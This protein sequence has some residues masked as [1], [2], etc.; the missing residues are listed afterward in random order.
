[1]TPGGVNAQTGRFIYSKTDLEI[2]P[3]KFVRNWGSM[4]NPKWDPNGTR[5]MGLSREYSGSSVGWNH[6]LN[7]GVRPDSSSGVNRVHVYAGGRTYTFLIGNDGSLMPMN[8]ESQGTSLSW[9]SPYWF[10]INHEGDVYRFDAIPQGSAASVFDDAQ[11]GLA[12]V[13]YANGARTD[14]KY[15]SSGNPKFVYSNRGYAII[16]DYDANQNVSAVCGVNLATAY[17]DENS[18]CAASTFKVQYG[19]DSTGK[20]LTQVTDLRGHVVQISY[21]ATPIS[22]DIVL[23]VCISLPNSATCAIHNSYAPAPGDT[24][25]RILPD[26]VGVQTMA[27]GKVWKFLYGPEESLSDMPFVS[28]KPRHSYVW[29]TDPENKLTGLTFDRGHLIEHRG[30][31]K[32]LNY[33]YA[34]RSMAVSPYPGALP[35]EYS[36]FD[37]VPALV[38]EVEGNREY[39]EHDGRRNITVR[40]SWPK[41]A[42]MPPPPEPDLSRCCVS[43][44]P[45][46]I[47]AGAATTT[48][49]YLGD[50]GGITVG[51]FRVIM[52][53]G[54]GPVDEKLC[55]KPLSRTDPRG[56]VTNYTYSQAHGGLLTETGPPDAN[57]VRPQT[58]YSYVER[59]AWVAAPGGGYAQVG[60]PVWLLESKSLC[61]T[62]TATGNPAAPCAAGAADEVRT[63]YDYGPNAGPNNLELRGVVDDATGQAL[64]TCYG[65]DAQGNRIWETKPRAGLASCS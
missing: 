60:L 41:G 4:P 2:G 43:P 24:T 42:A 29:I 16:L 39:F 54:S 7:Q 49:T 13:V 26:Q 55:D 20:R 51:G 46:P 25:G 21:T 18:T 38:S 57:G 63:L 37:N 10:F 31:G 8:H 50:F 33:H 9:Q 15:N 6:S 23:P 47:P 3:L 35:I 53:C 61:K 44:N 45:L 27:D 62:S 59:T 30:P 12:Y 64:R 19:Y 5:V 56:N 32:Y 14:Y 17:A 36:Y 48:Y 34:S 58:R 65:Y 1:M 40:S 22:H 52:G 28:G 11:K